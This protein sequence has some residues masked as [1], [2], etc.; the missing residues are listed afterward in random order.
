[1]P[2]INLSVPH[3]L[4]QDAAKSRISKLIADTRAQFGDKVT[5]LQEA[6]TGNIDTFSFSVMGFAVDGRLEVQPAGV[7]IDIN[8]PWAALPF[9]GRIESEILRHARELL[10]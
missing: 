2:K 9:K 10:A 1:M 8:L 7:L 5:G 4:G 6:W 3:Q